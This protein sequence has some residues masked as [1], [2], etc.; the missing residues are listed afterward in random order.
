MSDVRVDDKINGWE[1]FDII[2]MSVGGET[3]ATLLGNFIESR[4]S[5][6]I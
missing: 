5:S 2:D 3:P 6:L 4:G 1:K